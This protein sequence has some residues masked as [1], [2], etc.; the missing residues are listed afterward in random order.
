[1]EINANNHG[2]GGNGVR[3]VWHV[4]GDYTFKDDGIRPKDDSA[5]GWSSQFSGPGTGGSGKQFHWTDKN[6]DNN[7]YKYKITVY[8]KGGNPL[9]S[10]PGIQNG[11]Q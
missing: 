10:D 7:L 1:L 3:I 9:S 8:D 2:P 5:A 11:V 4:S 6:T